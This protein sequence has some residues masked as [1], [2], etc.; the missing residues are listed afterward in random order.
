MKQETR[1]IN[2]TNIVLEISDQKDDIGSSN[3]YYIIRFLD[4]ANSKHT[5]LHV[6]FSDHYLIS[7]PEANDINFDEFINRE[8]NDL[9]EQRW[10]K[11]FGNEE[12]SVFYNSHWRNVNMM[13]QPFMN[14]KK[15]VDG[16][17]RSV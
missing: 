14:K 16:V 2:W 7:S 1:N 6:W 8:I 17:R 15:K 13:F 10:E 9:I 3:K 11:V 12:Y 5:V 4:K